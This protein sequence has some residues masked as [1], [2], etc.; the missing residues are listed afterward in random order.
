MDEFPGREEPWRR[1][2]TTEE[3]ENTVRR[4]QQNVRYTLLNDFLMK[5]KRVSYINY[6]G[7]IGREAVSLPLNSLLRSWSVRRN[8]I[9]RLVRSH[10]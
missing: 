7:F 6:E 2:G 5:V 9:T 4:V 10:L 8:A 3:E 1:P